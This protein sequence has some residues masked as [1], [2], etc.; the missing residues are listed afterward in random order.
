MIILNIPSSI[1]KTSKKISIPIN[2]VPCLC[3]KMF[4]ILLIRNANKEN[5][6]VVIIDFFST[7]II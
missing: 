1:S 3:N 4:L 7:I 5:T 6:A 2:K